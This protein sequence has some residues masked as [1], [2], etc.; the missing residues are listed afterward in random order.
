MDKKIWVKTYAKRENEEFKK[1][2]FLIAAHAHA[3][4]KIAIKPAIEILPFFLK[5]REG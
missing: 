4:V 1:I 3:K 2:Q 5:K